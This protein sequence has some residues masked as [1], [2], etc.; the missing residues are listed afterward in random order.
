MAPVFAEAEEQ[1]L[2]MHPC[3]TDVS[4]SYGSS[5][6][7]AAQIVTGSPADV[8]VSAVRKQ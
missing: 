4:F 7:L 2:T 3:V 6:T 5:A 1:F 8:Y